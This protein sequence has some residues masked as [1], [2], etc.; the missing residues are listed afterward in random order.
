MVTI[1]LPLN[2]VGLGHISRSYAV[3]EYMLRR[4][5]RPVMMVQG[6]YPEFF[7]T[8]VPGISIPTIYKANLNEQARIA[9]EIARYARMSGAG[10]LV[11]DTYPAPITLPAAIR[12]VLLVRPSSI[13]YMRILGAVNR[14]RYSDFV[15]T[16]HPDS[17]SWPYA[18]SETAEIAA[19]DNW[20]WAGPI[21]RAHSDH[22]LQ[23]VRRRYDLKE[24][25]AVYVFSLGGGGSHQDLALEITSFCGQAV[26]IAHLLRQEDPRCRLIF[27]RGPL[28]PKDLSIPDEF[29]DISRE[30]EM[31]ELLAAAT[32]AVIRPGFNTTWEC[33]AGNTPFFPVPGKTFMEPVGPRA[34]ALLSHGLA[35]RNVAEWLDPAW[36]ERFRVVSAQTSARWTPVAALAHVHSRIVTADSAACDHPQFAAPVA[37][38]ERRGDIPLLLRIDDVI[39]MNRN[40]LDLLEFCIK[41]ALCPS[42]E[43]I[44]YLSPTDEASLAAILGSSLQYEVSQ[45]G[46]SHLPRRTIF[47]RR[48]EVTAEDPSISDC[49]MKGRDML[50][51]RFP[52]RYR[53]GFS[54]PYDYVPANF[55]DTWRS[56]GGSYMSVCRQQCSPS[57]L[58]VICPLLDPWDWMQNRPVEWPVLLTEAGRSIES[59]GHVGIAIHPFL[60]DAEGE[61]DR[62]FEVIDRLLD[63]NCTPRLIGDVALGRSA[64]GGASSA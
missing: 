54:P 33:I 63:R 48:A 40:L 29:E 35:P 59:Q 51:G 45:H 38:A 14:N 25:E 61:R 28:F 52:T 37:L 42:L 13:E 32:G 56:M 15:I 1:F 49:L 3:A 31:P 22:K 6:Q 64:V 36:R 30:P 5:D 41:R 53:G 21:Y 11:E 27:V 2:G 18:E 19:W 17:P 10:A 26:E 43:V 39:T 50:Q 34:E 58:P 60:F 55:P 9:D 44:P 16:D 23:S 8:T 62:T 12:K 20:S 7:A 24:D 57:V 4:G 47:G 46:F